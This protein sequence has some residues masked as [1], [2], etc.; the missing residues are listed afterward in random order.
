MKRI[1]ALSL[2]L[3]LV[4]GLVSTGCTQPKIDCT[5]G[6]AAGLGAFAMK[7][8]LVPGSKTGDGT[9]DTF[10][11]EVV[12]LEKYNPAAADDPNHQDLTKA[13]LAVRTTTLGQ[14]AVDA[15]AAGVT[16]DE[17][18]IAS[19]GD[20]AS[21]APDENDVCTVP[22]LSTAEGNFPMF[23][24]QPATDVTYAWKNIRVHVTTAFEGTEMVG[25]V[26]RSVD[27]CSATYSVVG[28][29]PAVYC[30]ESDADGKGTGK[31]DTTWCDPVAHPEK[32]RAYGSGIYPDLK[33][34]VVCDPVLL[35][36]VLKQP[37][38]ALR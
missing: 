28:L 38:E 10:P 15:Q 2:G 27:G 19:V 37:P 6:H 12:G 35:Y 4:P 29:W 1:I 9:C 33:D 20:F 11:G 8:T 18:K 22:T 16:V 5:V 17:I 13:T 23:G 14:L 34:N 36:C 30:E 32:G 21:T 7:Y 25:E 3:A 26:T 31:P 24:A